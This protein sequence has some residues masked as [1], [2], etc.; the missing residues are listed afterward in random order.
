MSVLVTYATRYGATRE[1]AEAV[2]AA[3][4]EGGLEV[5][6][7]PA[8]RVRTLEHRAVVLGAPLYLGR[9]HEDA[10]HFLSQH[11]DALRTRPVAV[12]ALGPLSADEGEVKGSREQL[13]EELAKV[14]WL[15]PVALQ[16]FGGA[17]DPAKLSLPH[18]LLA[19]LPASPL[20]GLAKRD[21]RDWAAVRAWAE[22]LAAKL[23]PLEE[24]AT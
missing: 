17:Y 14:A 20:H 9:L 10:R 4:R 7:Q 16:V 18:R 11:R 5:Q 8:R 23:Q 12:F 22:G 24:A 1:V 2:A 19:A 3:L 13:D 21:A 6:V 15:T